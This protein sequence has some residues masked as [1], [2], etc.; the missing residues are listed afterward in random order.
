MT[1]FFFHAFVFILL[2]FSKIDFSGTLS[3]IVIVDSMLIGALIVGYCNCFM[4]LC[5]FFYVHSS[6]AIIL[7]GK[8][9]LVAL[10][11]LS[12]WYLVWLFT[13]MP[14]VC[15]LF[16]I[17]V[18]PDHTHYFQHLSVLNTIYMYLQLAAYPEIKTFC[19][20]NLHQT[21]RAY[22]ILSVIPHSHNLAIM[23]IFS[24]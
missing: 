24:V 18:F 14:W 9:E 11:C 13:K 1:D 7:S 23:V 4:F 16:V 21:I 20:I 22:E 5:A 15:M 2:T 10:L 17:V 6:I 3:D 8:R 19:K 12:S